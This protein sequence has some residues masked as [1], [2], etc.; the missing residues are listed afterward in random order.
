MNYVFTNANPA[1]YKILGLAPG[2]APGQMATDLFG[3][4]DAP[5]I[6]EF[7]AVALGNERFEKEIEFDPMGI[8]FKL[9]VYSHRPKSFVTVFED[10]TD[11]KRLEKDHRKT[12]QHLLAIYNTVPVGIL[13]VKNRIVLEANPCMTQLLGY[14]TAEIIGQETRRFYIDDE[15]WRRI[16]HELDTG[17]ATSNLV[18]ID[19]RVRHKDG[20]VKYALMTC[21]R[22]SDE[23][24]PIILAALQD[25]TDRKEMEEALKVSEGRFREIIDSS[26]MPLS[27]SNDHGKILYTNPAFVDTLGYTLED[28]PTI[29]DFWHKGY[30]DPALSGGSHPKVVATGYPIRKRVF[31]VCPHGSTHLRQGQLHPHH[32]G[33]VDPAQWIR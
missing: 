7:S 25:I 2:S 16:G 32:A 24:P 14:E 4:P 33:N 8:I 9:S 19:A 1:F 17:L 15:E 29:D 31:A 22:L 30:P 12:T 18:S 10:I 27:I 21:S 13:L 11:R 26:P 23:T 6:G 28:I 20:S 3:V 5:N